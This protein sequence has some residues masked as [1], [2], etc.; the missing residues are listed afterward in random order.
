M[1]WS[2]VY[3]CRCS[4]HR[5]DPRT[6]ADMNE[7]AGVLSFS[8]KRGCTEKVP[9]LETGSVTVDGDIASGYYRLSAIT[10]QGVV[11]RHDVATVLIDDANPTYGR[12]VTNSAACYS[13]LK[14]AD[15]MRVVVGTYAPK[16]SDGAQEAARLLRRCTPAPIRVVGGFVLSSNVVFP[17]NTTYLAAA[18]SLLDA[19]NFCM[20]ISG[21]GSVAI[22]PR[23]TR[24]SLVLDRDTAGLLMP[25]VSPN[26]PTSK[27]PNRYYAVGGSS[28][29]VAVNDDPDS[30]VSYQARGRWVDY[31]DT[32]PILINGESLQE[33]AER[34]LREMTRVTRKVSYTREYAPEVV[35]FSV[36]RGNLPDKGLTG[37]MTVISQAVAVSHGIVVQ[38]TCSQEVSL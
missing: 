35:P 12:A 31:V 1:D 22:M 23:P 5:V 27:V 33:Y 16:G 34:K 4:I 13:T 36:I 21:D 17:T 8:V 32:S 2:R 28:V 30:S 25:E 24:P 19:G 37:D 26:A 15:D 10:S 11:E 18:W 7:L 9:L 38:E 6:W 3:S 20:Q 29:A 14:P